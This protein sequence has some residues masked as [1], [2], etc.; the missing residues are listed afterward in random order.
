MS[1]NIPTT[2]NISTLPTLTPELAKEIGELDEH[3]TFRHADAASAS[4]TLVWFSGGWYKATLSDL[5]KIAKIAEDTDH[6]RSRGAG[7]S[8][9]DDATV[10]RE[11]TITED[12]TQDYD[13]MSKDEL[14][15]EC[16]S[17]GLTSSGTK[18]ELIE[19][20]NDDDNGDS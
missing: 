10:E 9:D 6:P 3:P 14:K 7:E 4:Y 11:D 2:S 12:D 17:R 16:E 5:P 15:A 19:G 20:L 18:A 8:T 13:E 1:Q